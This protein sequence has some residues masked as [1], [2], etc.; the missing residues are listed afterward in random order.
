MEERALRIRMEGGLEAIEAAGAESLR[1]ARRLGRATG[2][3]G[4]LFLDRIGLADRVRDFAREQARVDEAVARLERL[5]TA[6]GWPLGRPPR[7][8]EELSRARMKLGRAAARACLRLGGSPS[9]A[10]VEDLQRVEA[11]LRGRNEVVD[12]LAVSPR[13]TVPAGLPVEGSPYAAQWRDY[14]SR[15]RAGMLLNSIGPLWIAA[16]AA[17]VSPLAVPAFIAWVVGNLSWAGWMGR[18][19]CPRCKEPFSERHPLSPTRCEHC[20]LLRYEGDE[21]WRRQLKA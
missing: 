8:L 7:C 14:R 11:Q 13:P 15:R 4:W 21:A 16:L 18:F 3:V 9:G 6:E 2:L 5:G 10:V 1:M 19:E 20:G 17:S 12:A